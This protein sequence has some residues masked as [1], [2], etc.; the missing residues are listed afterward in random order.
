VKTELKKRAGVAVLMAATCLLAVGCG[1]GAID[2]SVLLTT[3]VTVPSLA[4]STSE[5]VFPSAVR[6]TQT[7][8]PT[9]VKTAAPV[10][11]SAPVASA[12]VAFTPTAT[13]FT[14][15]GTSKVLTGRVDIEV[16][17]EDFS[18]SAVTIATG[19]TVHWVVPAHENHVI[20][21]ENPTVAGFFISYYTGT[22]DTLFTTPG[23]YR[24]HLEEYEV[25]VCIVT[26]VAI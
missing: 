8:A 14:T 10:V 22:V 18:P 21:S 15:V 3:K 7:T 1:G 5:T 11:T 26:V 23:V 19:T 25:A 4:V 24:F 6:T 12:T 2:S 13:K 20:V 9:D 17:L 16:N